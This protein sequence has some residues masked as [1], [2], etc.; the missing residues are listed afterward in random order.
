MKAQPP[1]HIL[2]C[3]L[4]LVFPLQ[5]LHAQASGK[6]STP[7]QALLAEANELAERRFDNHKALAKYMEALAL[8]P[9]NDDILWRISRCYI[10]IGEHLP[11]AT[12]AEK[13][14]QLQ[15]YE[16]ALEF[17]NRAIAA[18]PRSSMAYTRRAIANGRIALFRGVWESIDLVKQTRKDLEMALE[19]DPRNS[20]AYYVMGRTHAK[21]SEKPKIL[22]WPLGLS[23][24]SLEEAVKNYEMAI[25]LRPD[26]IMYRLDC[27]RAYYEMGEYEKAREHLKAIES[28]PTLDEDDEQ[29]RKEAKEL[30]EKTRE[31]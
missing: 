25:R 5:L 4:L 8:E 6:D 15:T 21:V 29:F 19:L 18:N 2:C 17:A 13:E 3:F 9:T 27:A 24:A 30:W 14:F 12:D 22:R 23:W 10:D 7:V 1:S 16:K 20:T 31:N 28:L 11:T 26:F